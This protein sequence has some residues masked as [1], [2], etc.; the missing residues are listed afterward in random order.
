MHLQQYLEMTGLTR[1]AFAEKAGI[2]HTT[3]TLALRGQ[4]S[5]KTLRAI[6]TA[7]DGKV[8]PNDVLFPD[9]E[10]ANGV[11]TT[12]IVTRIGRRLGLL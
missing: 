8:T 1:S 7:S 11:R 2:H 12:S 5:E 3:V 10:P 6:H 9:A 4:G